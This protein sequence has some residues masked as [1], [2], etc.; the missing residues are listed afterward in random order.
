MNS[1]KEQFQEIIQK[2]DSAMLITHSLNGA[3]RARPMMVAAFQDNELWFVTSAESTTADE[4]VHDGSV[5]I[6]MQDSLKYL[7]I[8]GVADI[9]VDRDKMRALWRPAWLAWFDGPDDRNA[10]LIRVLPVEAEVWDYSGLRAIKFAFEVAKAAIRGRKVN[11]KKIEE[12]H[13]HL[14]F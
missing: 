4:I 9:V 7:S 13:A 8:S 3:I 12:G 1:D 10:V 11:E 14:Q 6:T 5:A 2:F